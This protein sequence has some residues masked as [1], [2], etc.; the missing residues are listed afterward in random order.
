ML[1]AW[2]AL[3]AGTSLRAAMF[4]LAD[5]PWLALAGLA[6]LVLPLLFLAVA[7]FWAAAEAA[8]EEDW[9][10][11]AAAGLSGLGTA[12][13]SLCAVVMGLLGLLFALVG[14]WVALA[15]GAAASAGLWL[16]A[17]GFLGFSARCMLLVRAATRRRRR[18]PQRRT[19]TRI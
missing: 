9:R 10:T 5:S 12:R 2:D 17:A 6:C 8:Q 15:L 19:R 16:G 7:R 1:Y 3:L 14:L 4:G 18:P 11:D 13:L